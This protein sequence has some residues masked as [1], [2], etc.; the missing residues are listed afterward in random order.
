MPAIFS[1]PH[2]HPFFLPPDDADICRD[3]VQ[4]RVGH[5]TL[6]PGRIAEGVVKRV[7]GDLRPPHRKEGFHTVLRCKTDQDLSEAVAV[8]SSTATAGASR[9]GGDRGHRP[10]PNTTQRAQSAPAP[11]AMGSA[12]GGG[13]GWGGGGHGRGDAGGAENVG[14]SWGSSRTSFP[15]KPASERGGIAGGDDALLTWGGHNLSGG[16]AANSGGYPVDG[17]FVSVNTNAGMPGG[18]R[19]SEAGAGQ[20]FPVGAV[21]QEGD[22]GNGP[23]LAWG[24][25]QPQAGGGGYDALIDWTGGGVNNN[26]SDATAMNAS[27]SYPSLPGGRHPGNRNTTRRFTGSISEQNRPVAKASYGSS[28]LS[29]IAKLT[30]Q[31]Q[32]AAASA[33]LPRQQQPTAGARQLRPAEISAS[34]SD[35]QAP[36]R[37]L[38]PEDVGQAATSAPSSRSRATG[39]TKENNKKSPTAQS[40]MLPLGPSNL[41]EW[42]SRLEG[43]ETAAAGSVPSDDDSSDDSASWQTAEPGGYT[44]GDGADAGSGGEG[45]EGGRR[46]SISDGEAF[47]VLEDMF[48][49]LLPPDALEKVFL[50][51]RNDL[52]KV[53]RRESFNICSVPKCETSMAR[54]AGCHEVCCVQS[55]CAYGIWTSKVGGGMTKCTKYYKTPQTGEIFYH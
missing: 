17:R 35:L 9:G 46:L 13:G 8:L 54:A 16:T 33:G 39:A 32:T 24:G 19:L 49:G 51:S 55:R 42:T 52:H 31:A 44:F 10:V 28:S 30:P 20:G 22:Y 40:A 43:T 48:G 36:P 14:T 3:R 29:T 18:A 47:F 25:E 11:G 5:P 4:R 37:V 7:A 21:H 27:A 12:S 38:A 26:N 1:R 50:E 41:E 23:V 15:P 6:G 34:F 2:R 45:P 53:N